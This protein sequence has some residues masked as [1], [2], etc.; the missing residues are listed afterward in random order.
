MKLCLIT[1]YFNPSMWSTEYGSALSLSRLGHEVTILTSKGRAPREIMTKDFREA[2][3]LEI[4][5]LPTIADIGTP[6]VLGLDIKDCDTVL[7]QEDYPYICQRAFSIASRLGIKTILLYERST[8]LESFI[9]NSII[10]ILSRTISKSIIYSANELVAYS[11][12]AMNFLKNELGVNREIK[13]IPVGV[14][15]NVFKPLES[16]GRYLKE[17]NPKIL[18]VA[19]LIKRKGLDYLI[20]SVHLVKEY[21]PSIKLYIKGK[22]PEEI[23]LRNLIKNLGLENQVEFIN[24]ILPYYEIP[25]LYGECDIYVQ[26]SVIEPYGIAPLEAM[27]CGK[28]VIGAK[29]GIMP[30]AIIHGE[31]GFL[32]EPKNV[33]ELASKI[34]ELS[35]EKKRKKM[36]KKARKLAVEKFSLNATGEKF[37]ELLNK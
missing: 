8:Y 4:R 24:Q 25:I 21:L 28:P 18:T 36:G 35:D 11:S 34:L 12:A 19:R 23:N 31:T 33:K 29:V 13:V 3:D 14:D 22:G 26:P 27:A 1:P 16:E 9:R 15:I 30:D 10:K 17:G 6:I 5:Y 37:Q 32:A 20:K 2:S 7:L